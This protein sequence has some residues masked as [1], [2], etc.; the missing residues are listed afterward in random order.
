V[1]AARAAAWDGAL[2]AALASAPI[3]GGAGPGS[4]GAAGGGPVVGTDACALGQLGAC[5]SPA[6]GTRGGGGSSGGG[7][8]SS[9]EGFG[10]ALR[11]RLK[12]CEEDLMRWVRSH[13]LHADSRCPLLRPE[14]EDDF[15]GIFV[16]TA[17]RRLLFDLDSQRTKQVCKK[18]GGK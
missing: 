18:R 6:I 2:E 13:V 3:G 7:S 15:F 12:L 5:L 14:K 8:G 11:S 1:L 16:F 10:G 4:G 17:A 9:G